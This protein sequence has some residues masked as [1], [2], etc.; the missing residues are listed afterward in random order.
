MDALKSRRTRLIVL[1]AANLVFWTGVAVSVGLLAG[2]AIDIGIE[3]LV[4]RT[5]AT[6]VAVFE[7]LPARRL[8]ETPAP[9]SQSATPAPRVLTA[10]AA[11]VTPSTGVALVQA[12]GSALTPPSS[13]KADTTPV[14]AAQ[15]D[16][17][18]A[19]APLLLADPPFTDLSLIDAEMSRSALS[20]PVQIRYAEDALNQEITGLLENESPLHHS[21]P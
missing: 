20:R 8:A 17:P 19:S 21:G 14:G 9:A 5:Q 1:A 15:S 4:R 13:G 7:R 6:A 10:E 11:Q 2:D 12:E 3:S 16:V 18:L